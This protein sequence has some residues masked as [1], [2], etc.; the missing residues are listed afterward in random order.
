MLLALEIGLTIGAWRRG[1]RGWALLP[2]GIGVSVG[3][4]VGTIMA[5]SGAPQGG[6]LAT[7]L[8]L[9]LAC[10]GALVGMVLKPRKAGESHYEQT[11]QVVASEV[12]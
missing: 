8:I 11:G 3:F 1:W 5:A 7:G 9:D 6:I 2:L 4:L 10:I 12:R